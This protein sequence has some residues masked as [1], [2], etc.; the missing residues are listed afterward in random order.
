[1]GRH[2]NQV[3]DL[4][5]SSVLGER[6]IKPFALSSDWT[7]VKCIVVQKKEDDHVTCSYLKSLRGFQNLQE[8][9]RMF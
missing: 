1:M 8:T 6:G 4:Y 9:L 7:I 3:S 5:I 2:I